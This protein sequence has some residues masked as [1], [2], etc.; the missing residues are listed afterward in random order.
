MFKD[1]NKELSEVKEKVR[2]KQRLSLRLKELKRELEDERKK[3]IDLKHIL[4]KE[5]KDVKKLESLSIGGLIY[6]LIGQKEEKIEKEKEEYILAKVRY[7]EESAVVS[8][9]EIDIKQ[10]EDRLKPFERLEEEYEDIIKKKEENVLINHP[11][12]RIKL[13]KIEEKILDYKADSKELKEAIAAGNSLLE[14]VR[15]LVNSLES[16]AN[17]GTLDMIGGGILSTAIKH[18][19]IDE[20]KGC[21]YEVKE[22][23]RRFQRE[24]KDIDRELN[25]D[26]SIGSFTTFADYFFDGFFVDWYVQSSIRDA[27]NNAVNLIEG[28]KGIVN[29]LEEERMNSEEEIAQL[30]IEYRKVIEESN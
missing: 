10:I 26:V 25:L 7:D 30:E 13:K 9:L 28:I 16:A 12:D 3:Q 4:D 6:T 8:S 27:L 23:M 22:Y 11:E 15:K 17:W 29:K 20:A 24:L 2:E 5:H 18:S 1:L 21:S 14:I 19:H